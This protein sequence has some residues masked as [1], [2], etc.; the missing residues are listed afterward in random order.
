[1]RDART[2]IC[3]VNSEGFFEAELAQEAGLKAARSR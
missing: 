3:E 1:M 2:V